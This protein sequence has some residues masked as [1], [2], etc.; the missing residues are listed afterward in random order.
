MLT[1]FIS[2]W[3]LL[4]LLSVVACFIYEIIDYMKSGRSELYAFT[5]FCESK[6]AA[7]ACN[8]TTGSAKKLKSNVPDKEL[9][10]E[11]LKK[12]EKQFPDS[13]WKNKKVFLHKIQ[14]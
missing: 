7:G 5:F 1:I 6:N 3:L 12:Y 11:I 8:I 13:D 4:V 2:P 14:L 9:E 10:N